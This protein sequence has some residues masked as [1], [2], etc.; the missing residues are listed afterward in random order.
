MQSLC[1]TRSLSA[2]PAHGTRR[3]QR[4]GGLLHAQRHSLA[5][6]AVSTS[7][8]TNSGAPIGPATA[9]AAAS[10]SAACRACGLRACAPSTRGPCLC[11]CPDTNALARIG[12]RSACLP[13]GRRLKGSRAVALLAAARRRRR[14]AAV[15]RASAVEDISKVLSSTSDPVAGKKYDYILV[16]GRCKHLCSIQMQAVQC[17]GA[18]VYSPSEHSCRWLG[19]GLGRCCCWARRLLWHWS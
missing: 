16:S 3:S 6:V 17:R 7:Q 13:S 8:M 12:C 14:A 18:V 19:A 5:P 2:A 15:T 11:C 4:A 1:S 9:A 10:G